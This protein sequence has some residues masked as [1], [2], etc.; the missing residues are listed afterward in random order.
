VETHIDTDSALICEGTKSTDGN[1]NYIWMTNGQ[2]I[3]GKFS[4]VKVIDGSAM[5]YGANLTGPKFH[6]NFMQD[7]QNITAS[8]SI[9]STHL[10]QVV[11]WLDASRSST[12]TKSGSDVSAWGS[13]H[14]STVNFTQTTSGNRP[15][16]VN[17]NLSTYGGSATAPG[18]EFN[19]SS[20]WM[21]SNHTDF[22]D[23]MTP[24]SDF[25]TIAMVISGGTG[26]DGIILDKSYVDTGTLYCQYRHQI[27]NTGGGAA[28]YKRVVGETPGGS[29]ETSVNFNNTGSIIIN[30]IG[31]DTDT[32]PSHIDY[33]WA[34]S[35]GAS[36]AIS[37][38]N[39]GNAYNSLSDTLLGAGID[40][41]G[42]KV[43]HF[44]GNIHELIIIRN[45]ISISNFGDFNLNEEMV[46]AIGR[47]LDQKW[48]NSVQWPDSY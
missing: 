19:G 36:G 16:A 44:A 8:N 31:A 5:I 10:G 24:Q 42:N 26:L 27:L 21:I 47:Y 41:S 28:Y 30:S 33:V 43:T 34:D 18:V 17:V 48:F 45:R 40:S 7:F 1:S 12:I 32:T 29:T 35:N 3:V 2:E 46:N 9:D 20:D 14:D 25:W 23:Y 11:C 37:S 6:V 38:Y 4:E 39:Y 13:V 22:F 15:V